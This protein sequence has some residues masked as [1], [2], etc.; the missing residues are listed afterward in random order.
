MNQSKKGLKKLIRKEIMQRQGRNTFGIKKLANAQS[1]FSDIERV[2]Q[3]GWWIHTV[4][5]PHVDQLGPVSSESDEIVFDNLGVY[6][7]IH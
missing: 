6:E 1:L 7:R 3:V 5:T 4:Q 2:L